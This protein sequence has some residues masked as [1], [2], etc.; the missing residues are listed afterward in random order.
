[1]KLRLSTPFALVA[2][3]GISLNVAAESLADQL[4]E[5][6]RIKARHATHH[7]GDQQT[8]MPHSGQVS[9]SSHTGSEPKLTYTAG[10]ALKDFPHL[11]AHQR[12]KMLFGSN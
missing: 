5:Q 4:H 8:T 9:A 11:T 2:C 6:G 3:L 12:K 1:M 7:L 10:S